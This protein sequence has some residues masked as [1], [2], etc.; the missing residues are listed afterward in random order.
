[1]RTPEEAYSFSLGVANA[2]SESESKLPKPPAF[3][4]KSS[5]SKNTMFGLLADEDFA[6]VISQVSNAMHSLD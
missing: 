2:R 5:A 4:A 6:T 1:M 3:Q